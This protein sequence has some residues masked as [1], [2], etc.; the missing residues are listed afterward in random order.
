M[1][2]CT[3]RSEGAVEIASWR[4]VGASVESKSTTHFRAV[5][6]NID[7][8]SETMPVQLS[9]AVG[10]TKSMH[11]LSADEDAAVQAQHQAMNSQELVP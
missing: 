9:R 7:I 1:L 6:D 4:G 2:R 8:A 10:F 11:Q 5:L 3:R